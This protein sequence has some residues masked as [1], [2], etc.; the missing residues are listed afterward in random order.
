[1]TDREKLDSALGFAMKAGKV[2]SGETAA[3]AALK[4]GRVFAAVIDRDASEKTKKRWAEACVNLGVPLVEADEVGRAIGRG[5]HMI[6]CITDKG[7]AQ[8]ILRVSEYKPD[9]GG[10]AN[11]KE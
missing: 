9:C 7:F 6:A 1:M 4:S 10:T 11:G 2:R 8:M 3:E 5:A